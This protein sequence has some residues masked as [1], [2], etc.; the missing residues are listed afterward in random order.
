[1][2]VCVSGDMGCMCIFGGDM[3]ECVCEHMLCVCIMCMYG[4][5]VCVCVM[6]MV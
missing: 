6:C 3:G 5:I 4:D 2:C 1:M